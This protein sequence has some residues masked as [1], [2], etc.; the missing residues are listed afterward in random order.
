MI[1]SAICSWH[2]LSNERYN[3]G[4][5]NRESDRSQKNKK[6]TLKKKRNVQEEEEM[7][8]MWFNLLQ[9]YKSNAIMFHINDYIPCV[10]GKGKGSYA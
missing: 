6:D 4:S 10:G 1:N 8:N 7:N 9:G 3:M 5:N 2:L